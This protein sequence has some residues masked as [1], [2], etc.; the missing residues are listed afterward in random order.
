MSSKPKIVLMNVFSA[1]GGVG[2]TTLALICGAYAAKDKKTPTWIVDVDFAGTNMIH[3]LDHHGF[4][5]EAEKGRIEL[6]EFLSRPPQPDKDG[7]IS[8]AVLPKAWWA[9]GKGDGLQIK[10]LR[11]MATK[12]SKDVGE[13]INPLLQAEPWTRFLRRRLMALVARLAKEWKGKAKAILIIFDHS[14]GFH[15]F[16]EGFI[17]PKDEGLEILQQ[18][19]E[20][21]WDIYQKHLL[22]SS[23]DVMD[24]Q[25]VGLFLQTHFSLVK[26]PAAEAARFHL[27]INRLLDQKVPYL[28]EVQKELKTAW[29]NLASSPN[30][31]RISPLGDMPDLR[32]FDVIKRADHNTTSTLMG[33]RSD[34][35]NSSLT[36]LF[37][38]IGQDLSKPGKSRPT[39]AGQKP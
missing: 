17:S 39:R 22:V 2:K 11:I 38:F 6:H 30:S 37:N 28:D 13:A 27:V 4:K 21:D 31:Q 9:L 36:N 14:P 3:G 33:R 25:A 18:E 7:Q 1:K 24:L 15:P 35:I 8:E 32:F 34:S 26:N 29:D 20:G 5:E 19:T 10:N 16:L 23:G 12:I